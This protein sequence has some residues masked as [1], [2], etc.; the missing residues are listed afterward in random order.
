ML[1][2]LRTPTPLLEPGERPAVPITL[3]QVEPRFPT[4]HAMGV[5]WTFIRG[6]LWRRITRRT[7]I[8]LT[9]LSL[10]VMIE[11]LG[12]L[13]IKVGQLLSLRSD[14]FPDAVCRELGR[15]QYQA[16]GFPFA[17]AK[18]TIEA[19]LGAPLERLFSYFEEAPIAAASVSQVHRAVLAENGAVVVVKVLR[20][21]AEAAFHRDLRNIGTFMS[22]IEMLK[23]A[24][25]VHW[26]K[27]LEALKA[28]VV[29][30][31][32][33]RFEA[34]NTR[35]MRK[36]LREHN[37]Y[38]PKVFLK[39]STARVLVS[40]FIPG[41]LMADFIR[42]GATDPERAARWA[43]E[44][45]IEPKKLAQKLFSSAV[46]QFLEDNLFHGDLHPGNI[47]L[48]KDNRFALIDFGTIGS[49]DKSF[50]LTYRASLIALAEKDYLRAADMT[51]RL[52]IKPPGPGV[53]ESLREEIV[54]SYKYWEAR[55]HL[56]GTN[57]HERSL[58]AAGTDSGRIMYKYHV[59]LT[60]EFMRIS[61]TWST[62]DASLSF[63]MPQANYM[64][65]FRKYF[66]EAQKRAMRPRV[67]AGGVMN[68]VRKTIGMV[69]EYNDMLGPVVR[70]QA[71]LKPSFINAGERLLRFMRTSFRIVAN[72]AIFGAI[73]GGLMELDHY[74]PE[75]FHFESQILHELADE[76][77]TGEEIWWISL[78]A[79]ILIGW[80]LRR[81]LRSVDKD[82]N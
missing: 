57:Y 11:R 53:L 37:V 48:L 43:A 56:S 20:P 40:E 2:V 71:I 70:K 68:A 17:A 73:I 82:P 76:E 27:G 42:V 12:G 31:I 49:A 77:L 69:E 66:K 79:T 7:D 74:H 3:E 1:D 16:Q 62:L 61:R 25:H 29:E 28:M 52:A 33:F 81:A 34:A 5:F 44:N 78:T 15:L 32:D 46:R 35:R 51:L 64:R 14:I 54:A 8:Q 24:P 13:W 30:E 4:L 26:R 75:L 59:Q 65:L 67:I 21:S 72:L 38:A 22:L 41:V 18:A 63:L 45:R 58:A 39:Y 6:M 80:M 55:S 9:A 36:S 23:F 47:L 60:W 10:R 19:E 50:L